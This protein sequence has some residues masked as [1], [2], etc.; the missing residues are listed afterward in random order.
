MYLWK[1]EVTSGRGVLAYSHIGSEDENQI[2]R[3]VGQAQLPADPFYWPREKILKEDRKKGLS[4]N[5][6]PLLWLKVVILTNSMLINQSKERK[7]MR[8]SHKQFSL[9]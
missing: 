3:F 9:V 1:S 7:K 4:T 5:R 6:R 8:T 2:A